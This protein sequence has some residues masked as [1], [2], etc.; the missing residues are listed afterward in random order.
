PRATRISFAVSLHHVLIA[1]GTLSLSAQSHRIA[2]IINLEPEVPA[3][4]LRLIQRH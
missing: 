2:F 1:T 3:A 4:A